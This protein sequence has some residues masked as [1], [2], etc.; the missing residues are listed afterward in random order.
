MISLITE[1]K[2]YALLLYI[3]ESSTKMLLD[4]NLQGYVCIV[5]SEYN[6]TNI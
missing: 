1:N 3:R 2:N 4:A 5:M 6:A